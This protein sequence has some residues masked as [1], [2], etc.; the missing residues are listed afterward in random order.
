MQC[1]LDTYRS[2]IVSG[3]TTA[4]LAHTVDRIDGFKM[5]ALAIMIGASISM[6]RRTGMIGNKM[7][8]V[9]RVAVP[10]LMVSGITYATATSALIVSAELSLVLLLVWVGYA[11]VAVS[12][13]Q[14]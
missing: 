6:F 5:F 14:H 13:V 7:T 12:R 9:G 10:A 8:I 2:L 3:A 11:G 1:A 4:T